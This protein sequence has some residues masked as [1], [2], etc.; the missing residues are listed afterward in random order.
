MIYC[1]NRRGREVLENWGNVVSRVCK[2]RLAFN[3]KEKM[4]QPRKPEARKGLIRLYK[5]KQVCKC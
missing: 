1:C 2:E 5:H 3:Y 4:F